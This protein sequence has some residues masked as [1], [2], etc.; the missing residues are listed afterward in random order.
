M[1]QSNRVPLVA[2]I[3]GHAKNTTIE[4][5]ALAEALGQALVG[6][7]YGVVCG[8]G[9]GIMEAV[10]K[11]TIEA[12]GTTV[13]ILKFNDAG[14]G[15][16]FIKVAIPTAM[17]VASNNVIVWSAEAVIALEGR[18]GTLNEMALALD[19]GKPLLVL[20]HSA[21]LRTEEV[22]SKLFFHEPK[23]SRGTLDGILD[24]MEGMI[25][26]KAMADGQ[27]RSPGV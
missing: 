22:H 19:F 7:G 21:L 4:A 14:A 5:M 12:G 26:V 17:D 10:C 6:R 13:G 23:P 25:A 8:G 3:G 24:K 9:D 2:V 18:Y 20:G 16:P 11:G 27:S 15:N 1:S